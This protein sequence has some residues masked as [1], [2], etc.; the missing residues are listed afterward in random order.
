MNRSR[1]KP[2]TRTQGGL[3]RLPVLLTGV[4]LLL[5]ET[6][7][8]PGAYSPFRLP[9]MATAV[10]GL[11]IIAGWAMACALWRG[12]MRL[13]QGRIPVILAIL[14]ALQAVS[15]IWAASPG[16]ALHSA[17]TSAVWVAGIWW[18]G[19]FSD[20]ERQHLVKWAAGGAAISAF[21]LLAQYVGIAPFTLPGYSD[22]SRLRLTGLAGNPS[23]L[24]MAGLLMLPLL[25]PGQ[26]GPGGRRSG[27]LLPTVFALTAVLGQTMTGFASIFLVALGMLVLSHSRKAW[28]VA[29]A[30]VLPG[31]VLTIATPLKERVE[32]KIE[33]LAS[34]DW[35][36][37]L[38]AREDGWSA[39]ASMVR[40]APITGIGAGNYS[41]EFFPARLAL[42]ES[43]QS[44]GNRGELS[45]HFEWA[46][47]DPF[48]L[49]AELGIFA[50]VWMISLAGAVFA[51]RSR[52]DPQLFLAVLAWGPFLFV[53]Y[54]THLAV[55][56]IPA[57]LLLADRLGPYKAI[58]VSQR[59][60]TVLRAA[61]VCMCLAAALVIRAQINS[62]RIDLWRGIAENAI[63]S[64]AAAPEAQR[65]QVIRAVEAQI[66]IHL[67]NHPEAAGWLWRMAGRL[68]L[69]ARAYPEAETAFRRSAALDPH[70][71]AEMG[72][73]LALAGQGRMSEALY[74]LTRACRLNITLA[75]LISQPELRETVSSR[76]INENIGQS[77]PPR[78][79]SWG[80][81]GRQ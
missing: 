11:T 26:L 34:G 25:L 30:L 32:S 1:S 45:T 3:P 79:P 58:E 10:V 49:V 21:V 18:I 20:A 68:R 28:L 50:L 23:D 27:W 78:R 67:Q 14:P 63:N 12:R 53:H 76:L 62:I 80:V 69:S 52:P 13:P 56:L 43:K 48:Q 33:R 73:G 5:A 16:L 77:A 64:V 35:Y 7:F 39:A 8:L 47:N 36:F 4:V 31:L 66:G 74:H 65:T 57:A 55:G 19:S 61:A 54:P 70:E 81:G 24:A 38:S 60:K 72:L 22:A 75:D 42:L 40:S 44:Y 9:K 71:E 41:R 51:A 46:H 6:V 37:L 17:T 29:A 2:K 59:R 15:A